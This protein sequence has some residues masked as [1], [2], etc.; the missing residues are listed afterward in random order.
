MTKAN[1]CKMVPEVRETLEEFQKNTTL[2]LLRLGTSVVLVLDKFG[3]SES[4]S[5]FEN[6][7]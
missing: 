6:L 4:N 7:P 5:I 2:V 1:N 3:F